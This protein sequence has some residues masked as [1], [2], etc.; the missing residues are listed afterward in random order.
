MTWSVFI[1][2]SDTTRR[3]FWEYIVSRLK[4]IFS[5]SLVVLLAACT[6]SSPPPAGDSLAGWKGNVKRALPVSRAVSYGG[7]NKAVSDYVAASG[8]SA[9]ASTDLTAAA[10]NEKIVICGAALNART[11][12]Q[13]EA[14]ALK[15]CQNGTRKWSSAYSGKCEIHASK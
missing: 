13:A 8:H 7:C 1:T 10:Y 14:A 2:S 11:V 6:T 4:L 5:C 3:H 9:Y 12:E 15:Q